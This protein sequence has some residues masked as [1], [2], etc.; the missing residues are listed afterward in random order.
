[1]QNVI[2]AVPSPAPTLSGCPPLQLSCRN[3]LNEFN[4]PFLQGACES[5]LATTVSSSTGLISWRDGR[6]LVLLLTL[7]SESWR[8][9]LRSFRG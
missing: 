3:H 9:S 2:T 1:M 6:H 8:S 5:P 4:D 7:N